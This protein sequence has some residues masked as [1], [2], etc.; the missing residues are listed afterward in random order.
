MPTAAES[1]PNS[2]GVT[3]DPGLRERYDA[4]KSRIA[5]AAGRAGRRAE[6][7]LLVAV[8]KQ[9]TPVQIAALAEL[10]QRDFGENRVQ[11]L[12]E[13]VEAIAGAPCAG[14]LR[15][16][17]IGT[18]QRNKSR[19]AI[20]LARLIH[21]VDNLRIAETL[22]DDA[23]RKDRSVPILIQVNISGEAT[24]HG[25]NPRAVMAVVEQMQNM[26]GLDLRGLMTMAPAS[27]DPSAARPVFQA[28]RELFEDIRRA[29][30][31]GPSFNVLSMG[32]SGDFEVAIECGANMVRVGTAIFGSS[33]TA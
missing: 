19:K 10:G 22:H 21:S 1:M 28:C 12:V 9:A 7:V 4:V 14:S 33:Q 15:W 17:L 11:H 13:R 25:M 8:S 3:A 32:M 2:P 31:C 5:A 16:H 24:K 27:D 20:E 18:L 26:T 23:A 30:L 6:D 29:K